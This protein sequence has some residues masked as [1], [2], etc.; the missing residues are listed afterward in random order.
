MYNNKPHH[1]LH[2]HQDMETENWKLALRIWVTSHHI[3]L[4]TSFIFQFDW[5]KILIEQT[6]NS[7]VFIFNRCLNKKC[8]QIHYKFMWKISCFAV[9]LTYLVSFA[10]LLLTFETKIS[11]FITQ[12]ITGNIN[13][14]ALKY[15]RHFRH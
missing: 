3:T 13:V 6:S 8:L 1:P 4:E 14:L 12:A 7:S 2:L 11:D 10:T 15:N 5:Q 9:I